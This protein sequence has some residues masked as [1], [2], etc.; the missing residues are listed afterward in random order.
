MKKGI[1]PFIFSKPS[2][3]LREPG[4]KISMEVTKS[5][6][7]VGKINTKV[8]KMSQTLYPSTGTIV[9]TRT[10]RQG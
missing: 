3:I 9:E 8:L 1:I 10:I 6:R 4:D 5:G 2:E 7:R